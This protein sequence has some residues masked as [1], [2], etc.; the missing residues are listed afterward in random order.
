VREQH[1]QQCQN[2][3]L[4]AVIE[5]TKIEFNVWDMQVTEL[6]IQV[7]VKWMQWKEDKKNYALHK[8]AIVI[9]E[10][11]QRIKGKCP[12]LSIPK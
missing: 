1:Y 12:T 2:G 8:T 7:R 3:W 10:Q 4:K 9:P 5:T 6:A 11:P